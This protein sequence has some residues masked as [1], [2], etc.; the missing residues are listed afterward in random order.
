MK[1]T[2]RREEPQMHADGRKRENECVDVAETRVGWVKRSEPHHEFF[3]DFAGARRP[4]FA[5]R[6]RPT[7]HAAIPRDIKKRGLTLVELLV[8][9]VIIAILAGALMGG[10]QRATQLA[11]EQRTKAT[12]A[13][14]HHYL[15]MKL[16]TYKTRRITIL[17]ASNK[18]V[19]LSAPLSSLYTFTSGTWYV[20]G[21]PN[22]KIA[23]Y[24]RLWGIRDL[25]R[26]EM[27]DRPLD[28]SVSAGTMNL[29]DTPQFHVKEP[30]VH[31][32]WTYPTNYGRQ[33]MNANAQSAKLLYATVMCGSAEAREQFQATEIKADKAETNGWPYDG[34]PYF[35]D[36]WGRPIVWIRWAPGC[37]SNLPGG[38]AYYNTSTTA[39]PAGTNLSGGFSD[40]QSGNYLTDHDPFDPRNLQADPS[41]LVNQAFRLIP[42]V[43]S[44]AGHT[45]INSLGATVDDYG[46]YSGIST[47]PTVNPFD[48]NSRDNGA[49]VLSTQVGTTTVYPA[50][51]I[52]NHHIE[53]K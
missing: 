1:T 39:L 26:M 51:P 15:M 22:G 23:A 45:A 11:R 18:V 38:T 28:V 43:L 24:L 53:T 40:I 32:M 4:G 16:E 12:I 34:W 42:L 6:P 48:D 25:M 52:H 30:S 9:M 17:D 37:S 5:R 2:A 49:A 7:L 29:P 19:D 31:N 14:I 47:T 33:L 8:V 50:I 35:V 3:A 46:V 27:P 41:N 36:G 20:L 13:K 21:M 10:L 44:A